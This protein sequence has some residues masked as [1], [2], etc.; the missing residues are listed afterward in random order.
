MITNS[1]DHS[2]QSYL[3]LTTNGH[4]SGRPH[5]IEIW[6]VLHAGRYYLVSEKRERSHWV[7]NIRHTP[8]LVFRVGGQRFNGQGRVVDPGAEPELAAAVRALMNDKYGWS[9]GL[10]VELTPTGAA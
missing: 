5:E 1:Q 3:Y 8:A 9:N 7:Q 6:F 2:T 4:K 10:I